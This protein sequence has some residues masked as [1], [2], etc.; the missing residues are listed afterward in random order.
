[1]RRH[2]FETQI[3]PRT[4]EINLA[5]EALAN[6]LVVVVGGARPPVLL[7]QVVKYLGRFCA[8]RAEQVVVKCY[9]RADFLLVFS[10]KQV[11]D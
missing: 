11:T 7:D 10:S 1:V 6:V 2:L 9:N 5:E 3:I 4:S 8:V